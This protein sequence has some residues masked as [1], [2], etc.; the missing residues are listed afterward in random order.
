MSLEDLE[1]IRNEIPYESPVAPV[2]LGLD[3]EIQFHCHKN[4]SCFNACCKNTDITLT[5]YDIQRLKRR[6]NMTSSQWVNRF[7]IPF[8]LDAHAM[9]GLKLANRPGSNACIFLEKQG[10]SVYEDRPA[11]CRYYALGSMGVRKQ[12][13]AKVEDIYFLVKEDHCKGHEEPRKLTVREYLHEQGIGEYDDNNRQWRDIVLKK[14]SSGPT[15]GQ[16]TPRSL[17]LFDMCSYDIDSFRDFFNS[18]GFNQVFDLGDD[19][20]KSLS[21]D[22]DKLFQFSCRFLKQVLFGEMRIPVRADARERRLSKRPAKTDDPA[23]KHTKTASQKD[24]VTR[25]GCED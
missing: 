22:E 11:A 13:D 7:T 15:I 19:E 4:I 23:V 20:K 2:E 5:P 1:N 24:A 18:A 6:L 25:G 10:C 14:R 9:P 16:P 21:E 17:Q 3:S 12:G 8:A